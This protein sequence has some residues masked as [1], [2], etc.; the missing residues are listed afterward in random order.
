MKILRKAADVPPLRCGVVGLVPT[1]GAYH[2]GHL[3]LMRAARSECDTVFV[4]LFVNP[5]QF[6]PNEDY[7]RYPRDEKRDVELADSVGVDFVF[8]PSVEEMFPRNTT[9]VKVEGVSALWEGAHRPGHFDGV[10]TVVC[11]LLNIVRPDVAFFGLKDYQQCA[12]VGAMVEDLNIPVRLRLCETVREDNGLAMSSRNRY[13]SADERQAAARL[14]REL[15]TLAHDLR[16]E[17]PSERDVIERLRTT[18]VERLSA[19]GFSLDYLALVDPVTL[20]PLERLAGPA[21][22][23]AAARL[24]SVRLIDN[25][26]V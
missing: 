7:T 9:T 13:L 17:S 2:E 22:L 4:S 10:A 1:M 5:T 18:A 3:S 8:A 11:K 23:L 14:Y 25:V 24:G 16:A 12:V 15:E 19:C 6:G 21:R 20:E 26:A